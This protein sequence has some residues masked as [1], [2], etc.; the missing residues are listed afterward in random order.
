M[1]EGCRANVAGLYLYVGIT[2]NAVDDQ[3]MHIVRGLQC[4]Q[5][6]VGSAPGFTLTVSSYELQFMLRWMPC[7]LMKTYMWENSLQAIQ[8]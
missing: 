7:S 2:I 1:I 3:V 5:E 4:H 8:A 6:S